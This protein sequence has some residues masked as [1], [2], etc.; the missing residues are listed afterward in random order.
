MPSGN[1]KS[2]LAQLA[3]DGLG[4]ESAEL[5]EIARGSPYG[6]ALTLAGDYSSGTFVSSLR[7][8]PD[9][10]GATLADFGVSVGAYTAGT[11]TIEFTLT[12]AQTGPSG[13]LP[14]DTDGDGLVWLVYDILYTPVG[15]SAYRIMGGEIPVSGKVS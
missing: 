7:L 4:G 6:Y 8:G 13:S 11:T 5:H 9:A 15:S 14:A 2:W 3:R 12:S 10:A 1:W